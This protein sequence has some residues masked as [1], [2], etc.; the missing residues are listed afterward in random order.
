MCI[1]KVEAQE[2]P[3]TGKNSNDVLISDLIAKPPTMFDGDENKFQIICK[4]LEMVLKLK[5][6]DYGCVFSTPVNK[7]EVQDYFSFIENPMDLGTVE[8][9]IKTGYYFSPSMPEWQTLTESAA[10][11]P[12][13]HTPLYCDGD[14]K[15]APVED[16]S[17]EKGINY[18]SCASGATPITLT[19]AEEKTLLLSDTNG[20]G[21]NTIDPSPKFGNFV[22]KFIDNIFSSDKHFTS[23]PSKPEETTTVAVPAQYPLADDSSM[24]LQESDV[25]D[26][27]SKG[28]MPDDHRLKAANLL[29]HF[30]QYWN[31][32]ILSILKDIELVYH[33]CFVYNF[34]DTSIYRQGEVQ[35]RKFH[36]LLEAHVKQDLDPSLLL[37]FEDYVRNLQDTRGESSQE[38]RRVNVVKTALNTGPRPKSVF[39]VDPST[40]QLIVSYSS[41]IGAFEACKFLKEKC[42]YNEDIR[43]Y[44]WFAKNVKLGNT[45]WPL[46]GYF[47]LDTRPSNETIENLTESLEFDNEELF[48]MGMDAALEDEEK[49][50]Q[51][52]QNQS[53]VD[54]SLFCCESENVILG[55]MLL[56]N[57][58]PVEARSTSEHWK[59]G[60]ADL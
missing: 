51:L 9:N 35:R 53:V 7:E 26:S 45:S 54:S 30:C 19:E 50:S 40:N 3:F 4:L 55:D 44:Q 14:E 28:L 13:P 16:E 39:V 43:N 17:K 47:W 48:E 18:Y 36:Y 6:Y 60:I 57:M 23:T 42:G 20:D 11:F 32:T 21:N 37:E 22:K 41:T 46:F 31:Y 15:V 1:N 24:V 8:H 25:G 2:D 56:I 52:E 29:G 58:H 27:S 10:H 38:K 49:N 34:D 59:S 12:V 33:N 5:N